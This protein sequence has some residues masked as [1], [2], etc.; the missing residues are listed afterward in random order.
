MILPFAEEQKKDQN[1][2]EHWFVVCITTSFVVVDCLIDILFLS[3][4][5]DDENNKRALQQHNLTVQQH[6]KFKPSE[7][8]CVSLTH[9][10]FHGLATWPDGVEI[11]PSLSYVAI[12]V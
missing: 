8:K 11:V 5:F 3:N 7:L 6:G 12:Q 4:V 9:A 2:N 10:P 1:D